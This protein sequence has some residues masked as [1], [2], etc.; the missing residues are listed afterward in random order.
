MVY[1]GR[2]EFAGELKEFLFLI[3]TC[4]LAALYEH[5]TKAALSFFM[6]VYY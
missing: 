4:P 2:R 3:V 1:W 6:L 5:R